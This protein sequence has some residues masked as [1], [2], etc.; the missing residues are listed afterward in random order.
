[1]DLPLGDKKATQF[2][3]LLSVCGLVNRC[4]EINY[5]WTLKQVMQLGHIMMHVLYL[6]I[7]GS[8]CW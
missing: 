8:K 6:V 1:M 3:T 5:Q 2:H 7:P 4:F